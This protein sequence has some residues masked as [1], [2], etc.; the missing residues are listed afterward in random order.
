MNSLP[1]IGNSDYPEILRFSGDTLD[2]ADEVYRAYL[3]MLIPTF[4]EVCRDLA[5]E[6]LAQYNDLGA[7]SQKRVMEAPDTYNQLTKVLRR[8]QNEF[9]GYISNAIRAERAWAG[10]LTTAQPTWACDGSFLVDCSGRARFD[11]NGWRSGGGFLAPRLGGAVPLDH[12]SPFARKPMPVAEFRTV[13]YGNALPFQPEEETAVYSKINAAYSTVEKCHP[14]AAAFITRYAKAVIVRKGNTSK[15]TF[16]S[17]SRNAFIGQIVLLNAHELHVD[18]EYIAE[19]LIHESIHSLLWR[20]EILQHFLLDPKI[21]M[22]TVRSSWS[23][24]EIYY[25]TLLQA[26]FVWAGI[27][28]F[29]RE[30]M[31]ANATF[32]MPRM[33]E[34]SER[35]R[36]GFLT[37]QYRQ[38]LAKGRANL[39][40]HVWEVFLQIQSEIRNST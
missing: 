26:C 37:S 2:L 29:W 19:S 25:Y 3:E 35:A 27:Y 21:P 23:G 36:R 15:G 12:H 13:K 22:G 33:V 18:T 11:S 14:I 8:E 32:S 40:P 34:L 6:E 30:M 24:E 10:Q 31:A 17:A 20:A 7:D 16:Q 9:E 4:F 5:L 39:Q 38:S 1:T 28:W